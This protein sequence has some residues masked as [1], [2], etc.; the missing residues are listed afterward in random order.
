MDL[1]RALIFH[2]LSV[3]L[4]LG[5]FDGPGT[6][7]D[8]S[9][10]WC[11]IDAMREKGWSAVVN[12]SD[13]GNIPHDWDAEWHAC[14]ASQDGEEMYHGFADNPALAI[15]AAASKALIGGGKRGWEAH[16]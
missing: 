5:L 2:T 4:G 12:A 15:C 6:L 7:D 11:I 10:A 14:F 9:K 16:N 13:V 3:K 8:L 1:D